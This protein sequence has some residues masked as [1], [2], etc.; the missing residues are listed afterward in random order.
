MSAA[1]V[2]G[3]IGPPP[4]G[5][6]EPVTT[7]SRRRAW[8]LTGAVALLVLVYLT[9]WS[10]YAVVHTGDRY[11]QLAPGAPGGRAG[12]EIRLLSLV[13]S[14]RL[15][16]REAQDPQIAGAGAVFVVVE[17][18]MVQQRS[19]EFVNCSGADLLGPDGR[20]W[21]SISTD[22]LRQV[23]YCDSSNVVVG[24]PYRFETVY[25]V[26]LRYVDNVVG[27][28]LVDVSTPRR[29]PVLRPPA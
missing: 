19:V 27:V 24:Q 11:R 2:A 18:E 28:A 22:V 3:A 4:S 29:T 8:L 13:R 23:P 15:T 1:E 9:V 25:L 12:A 16:S 6:P 10:G 26:P 7:R 14:D 21:E 5:A 17:L 20:R